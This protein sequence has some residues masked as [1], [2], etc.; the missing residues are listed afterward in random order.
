MDTSLK[1]L[2]QQAITAPVKFQK[3]IIETAC[4]TTTIDTQADSQIEKY[5]VAARK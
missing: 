1:H 4:D 2:S 3:K 5:V